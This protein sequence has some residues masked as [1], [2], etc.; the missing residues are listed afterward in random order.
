VAACKGGLVFISDCEKPDCVLVHCAFRP[1][2]Q[3]ELSHCPLR[4]IVGRR[5]RRAWLLRFSHR[6]FVGSVARQFIGLRCLAGIAH[7]WRY[8][9]PRTSRRAFLRRFGRLSRLD[10]RILLRLDRHLQRFPEF[11]RRVNGA[12][13]A[14]FPNSDSLRRVAD[15]FDVVAIGIEHEGAVI[16]GMIMRTNARCAVVAPARSEGRLVESIN[17]GAVLG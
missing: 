4:H 3:I 6:Q 11:V 17:R 7:R 12:A 1:C 8:L 16:I 14:R 9:G 13:A 2:F 5:L 15:R 10:R